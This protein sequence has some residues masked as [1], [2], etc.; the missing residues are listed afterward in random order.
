M[1]EIDTLYFSTQNVEND[2]FVAQ[3]ALKTP[4]GA[5]KGS[6]L[7]IPSTDRPAFAK[8]TIGKPS[9]DLTYLSS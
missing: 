3:K 1:L 5:K 2:R 8:A 7:S 4:F 6:F 9:T